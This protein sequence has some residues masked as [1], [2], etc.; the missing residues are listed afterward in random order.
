MSKDTDRKR[1]SRHS[2]GRSRDRRRRGSSGRS[3]RDDRPRSRGRSRSRDE[4]D[5][6]SRRDSDRSSSRRRERSRSRYGHRSS[7]K[8]HRH[9]ASRN[10]YGVGYDSSSYRRGSGND[11]WSYD[12]SQP[13]EYDR[14]YYSGSGGSVPQQSSSSNDYSIY[15]PSGSTKP[16]SATDNDTSASSSVE[17]KPSASSEAN[18]ES[19][20]ADANDKE[21]LAE[22]VGG[23]GC[24][25]RSEFGGD[26]ILMSHGD[27]ESDI[28]NDDNESL[29]DYGDIGGIGCPLRSEFGGD[30]DFGDVPMAHDHF[31]KKAA[32]FL[33]PRSKD[34]EDD[35]SQDDMSI[36][37]EEEDDAHYPE[38]DIDNI[39]LHD[40]PMPKD[41]DR[42]TGTGLIT[43]EESE[44]DGFHLDDDEENMGNVPKA[45]TS[46]DS[47]R[48]LTLQTKLAIDETAALRSSLLLH[49]TLPA[50]PT[51]DQLEDTTNLLDWAFAMLHN[52]KELGHVVDELVGMKLD[53][54]D[55]EAGQRLLVEL[56]RY[57]RGRSA[58]PIRA[59]SPRNGNS[60]TMTL[61]AGTSSSSGSPVQGVI[62]GPKC[63]DSVCSEIAFDAVVLTSALESLKAEPFDCGSSQKAIAM[64]D[65]VKEY[66][67]L[68]H[69]REHH[70]TDAL[71]ALKAN[72][73]EMV[74]SFPS[75]DDAVVS[76]MKELCREVDSLRT[77]LLLSC[78]VEKQLS[79]LQK[80]LDQ[81]DHSDEIVKLLRALSVI[82]SKVV[83]DRLRMSLE[84]FS[85]ISRQY[86]GLHQ[87]CMLHL[88]SP[89][90]P[91][92]RNSA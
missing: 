60:G 62:G 17:I 30:D 26:D 51:T 15:G 83:G 6:Y 9:N 74:T 54:C 45:D 80:A 49:F 29:F 21:E 67:T 88:F 90:G 63:D 24:P 77:F 7:S 3:S 92:G 22:E 27:H 19:N 1:R 28:E 14:R 75:S 69:M 85:Q 12:S 58:V 71:K 89:N 87:R 5:C 32:T 47:S 23:A 52:G 43:P 86:E 79:K 81:H 68:R 39:H 57:L 33:P 91:L 44:D 55:A 2:R 76:S 11:Y 53:V 42:A 18:D 48:A 37:D 4:Y 16:V 72:L 31:S 65:S 50:N 36:S 25:L 70:V 82:P 40:A 78:S 46:C 73:E 38:V 64:I 10:G 84:I 20:Q 56:A 13:Y 8:S 61:S 35:R 41:S 66:L 34:G 59:V